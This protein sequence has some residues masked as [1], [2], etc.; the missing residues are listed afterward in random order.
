M[1]L[2]PDLAEEKSLLQ[3]ESL[4]DNYFQSMIGVNQDL[5]KIRE[6]ETLIQFQNRTNISLL[7]QP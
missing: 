1:S 2:L 5:D 7:S 4:I 3:A 6:I